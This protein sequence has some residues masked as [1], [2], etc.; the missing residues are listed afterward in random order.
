MVDIK[1]DIRTGEAGMNEPT[2]QLPVDSKRL[3]EFDKIL[4][5]YKAGK[6]SVER[7]VIAAEQ[8]WKLHNES[9]EYNA[10]ISLDE[11]FQCKSAWLHNV[12]VTKHADAM[13]NYPKPVFLPREPG[14]KQQAQMLSSVV[15][16]IME[17][18]GFEEIYSNATWQKF[19]TGTA[20]YMVT[21]DADA[22]NG[23]GE[24][25]IRNVDILNIFT[26]PGVADIQKSRY[27]FHCELQD[28]DLLEAD[29]PQLKNKLGGN[30]FTL[31]KY[32]YDDSVSTEGKSVVVDVYYKQRENGRTVLHYCKYVGDEV[33]FSTENGDNL[34]RAEEPQTMPQMAPQMPQDASM[35]PMG[36]DTPMQGMMPQGTPVSQPE[37][38][39]LY[40][41][42]GTY[43]FVFDCLF[44]VAASPYGYGFVDLCQNAQIQLDIMDRAFLKNVVAGVMP[45][46]LVRGEG[47]INEQEYM[48]LSKA[49]VH[50]NGSL[51]EDAIR[52]LD[53][54][55]LQGT[56][57][58]AYNNKITELRETSGNTDTATGST[59]ASVTS[60][61]AIAAL[62]EA[63]GKS[64]KDASRSAYRAYAKI[65]TMVVERIRQFYDLPRQYRIIGQFGQEQFVTF[66]NEG[67][68]PQY[69][70]GIGD[71]DLGYRLPVFDIEIVAAKK[72]TYSQTAQND[73]AIQLYNLGVFNP[74]MSTPAL[75][76]I[77]MMDFDG[78][79]ELM[80]KIQQT[81][82]LFTQMQQLSQFVVAL[83]QKY[84][85]ANAPAMAQSLGLN[86]QGLNAS[87]GAQGVRGVDTSTTETGENPIVERARDRANNAAAT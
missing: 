23:L 66:S 69:Q 15:P 49:V 11:A 5:K 73:L 84:E 72:G 9:V 45:R 29:Y 80:Q 42:G 38:R 24:V 14:D 8:W 10:G 2:A 19:K 56:Y 12:L 31:S 52:I 86:L 77:D 43:P 35:P 85:P 71:T 62:Q 1:Q 67:L 33:L 54:K 82:T 41:D 61:S 17:E 87:G 60:A 59:P 36:M 55:P 44:P 46:A 70:G 75:N 25:C 57:I 30:T 37:N 83:L 4:R 28:N 79:D 48:D 34:P 40:D 68:V 21:W 22:L 13:E 27:I 53:Y 18:T 39:G 78:K 58:T 47:G 26:E 51:G 16:L 65:I 20:V 3:Q 63:S 50:V 7:R 81:G 76:L 64:S 74:Q 6:S 32:I